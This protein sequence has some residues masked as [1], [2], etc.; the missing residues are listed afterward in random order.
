MSGELG[1]TEAR[2]KVKE[3][4]MLLRLPKPLNL[5]NSGKEKGMMSVGLL[6]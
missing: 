5:K 1:S 2:R 4:G 3:R 6:L